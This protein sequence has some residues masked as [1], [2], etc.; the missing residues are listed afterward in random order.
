MN[1]DEPTNTSTGALLQKIFNESNAVRV[2]GI[3]LIGVLTCIATHLSTARL[4]PILVHLAGTVLS[5]VQAKERLLDAVETARYI[6]TVIPSQSSNEDVGGS[7]N[8]FFFKLLT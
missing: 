1:S 8:N 3:Q 6:S 4:H 7:L 2:I 5:F